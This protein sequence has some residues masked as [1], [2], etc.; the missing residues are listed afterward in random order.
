MADTLN[1]GRIASHTNAH[2]HAPCVLLAPLH[3]HCRNVQGKR[4]RADVEARRTLNPFSSSLARASSRAVCLSSW[5]A[6]SRLTLTVFASSQASS[7]A[8]M[9]GVSRCLSSHPVTLR[10]SDEH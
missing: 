2:Y 5:S 10:C 1:N 9:H 3:E 6:A 4:G 7:A 8:A